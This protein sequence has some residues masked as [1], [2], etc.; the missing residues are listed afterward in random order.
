MARLIRSAAEPWMTVLIAVRSA[1]LRDAAGRR[2]DA[3]DRPAAAQDRLDAPAGLGG[4]E[5]PGDEPVDPGVFLK[6]GL[7][8]RGR[9]GL[10]DAQAA[11]EPVGGKPVDDAEID[12][13]GDPAHRFVDG[14]LVDAGRSALPRPCGCRGPGR[15]PG[16]SAG[17]S[18]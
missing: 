9:L 16:T 4:L 12:R 13:L 10:S 7:D 11:R 2:L 8:E 14:R 1:R 3:V 18:E 5:G 15:R 17:S 6:I